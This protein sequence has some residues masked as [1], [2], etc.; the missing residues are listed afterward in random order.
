[1]RFG[2][3]A[4]FLT[5]TPDDLRNFRIVVYSCARVE[6]VNG[7]YRPTDFSNEDIL[8]DFK[9]RRDARFQYPGLCA[10]EYRRIVDLVIKHIFNWDCEKKAANGIGLF[11][12]VLAWCLATEEQARKS[13]HGHFLVFV[14]DWKTVLDVLHKRTDQPD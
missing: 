1:M 8:T 5:V 3:P 11:A 10:E 14:K 4:I 7:D 2:L 13:L 9:F 6:K 12:E